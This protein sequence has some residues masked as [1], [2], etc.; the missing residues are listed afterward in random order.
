VDIQ[1]GT[2]GLPTQSPMADP[3][4]SSIITT[5]SDLI[6][7]L[8]DAAQLEH[9]LCCAYLFAAFSI[10]RRPEEGVSPDR[11]ADLR[12]W[13]S[14]LLLI[15]RQEMEHLGIVSNLLTAIGGMPYLQNPTFPIAV[16]RYGELPGLPLQRFSEGTI[17]RF[18]AFETPELTHLREIILSRIAGK[19]YPTALSIACKQI[20]AEMEWTDADVWEPKGGTFVP[21][22]RL[23]GEL[24]IT[25]GPEVGQEMWSRWQTPHPPKGEDLQ[26]KQALNSSIVNTYVEIP[27]YDGGELK[28]VWRFFYE[29]FRT[30]YE[31][32]ALAEAVE[33]LL[34]ELDLYS[35]RVR[36]DNVARPANIE[37]VLREFKPR[38]ATIGGFYRQIRKGF[39]RLCFR[40]RQPTGDGLFTGFQTGNP[41]I[42]ILDR[43]VH[44]MD[45]PTVGNLDSA[46]AAIEEI[47][48][49]GEAAF[50]KRVAS[51]YVRLK[52]LLKDFESVMAQAGSFEPARAIV[53]NPITARP[54]AIPARPGCTLLEH[55]D[56]VAVA[57]IFDATYEITLQM[58]A[59]FFAFPDDKVLESMAFAPLMT[60]AIRPLAEILGELN[61]AEHSDQKA[62]PPFQSS[63][64]DLLHPH[65][66]AAWTV[67]GERLQQIALVC[68]EVPK[69]LRPEHQQA[70]ERL[71]FIGK[72]INFIA[73]RLKTAVAQAKAGT[74]A[75]GAGN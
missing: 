40:D 29:T 49:N 5:R 2:P 68:A 45:L 22:L 73:S 30:V 26:T 27:Y 55:P 59:R 20:C 31:D 8:C 3:D 46:L 72:N 60:M 52:K 66:L 38:Y 33:L 51:H 9:G 19:D 54:P 42:G 39:L 10:K 28:A 70:G 18:L 64:R 32:D 11:L 61:A 12:N 25:Y 16:D 63:A 13:E 41:D 15:A 71:T 69:N 24:N 67:F 48:E 53:D 17:R 36:L 58:V 65:R 7:A 57:E 37:N 1:S 50:N 47:V 56:A 44:D 23:T 74:L 14:V 43:Y 4:R 21:I 62:G 34:G 35:L 75:S 6:Q